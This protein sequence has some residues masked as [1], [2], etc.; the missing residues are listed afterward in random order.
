MGLRLWQHFCSNRCAAF[1]KLNKV[2]KA[3]SDAEAC[4]GLKPEWE[5]GFFRKGCVLEVLGRREEA[6]AAFQ[7]AAKLADGSGP[8]SKE[9]TTKIKQLEKSI[10]NGSG[11]QT[12]REPRQP[13]G[14]NRQQPP[15]SEPVSASQTGKVA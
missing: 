3:L 9:V 12:G 7:Q 6:L 10:A 8:S 1:L 2:T 11:A 13:L 14:D 5:K 15:P 4:I